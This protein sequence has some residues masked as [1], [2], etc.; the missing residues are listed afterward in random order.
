MGSLH[1]PVHFQ[2]KMRQDAFLAAATASL[3]FRDLALKYNAVCTVG[4]VNV[5]P[6]VRNHCPWSNVPF[7][8]I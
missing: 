2:L 1:T 5:T 6:G 3:K 7:P 8:L 4:E